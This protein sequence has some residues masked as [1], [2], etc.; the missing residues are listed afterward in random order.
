VTYRVRESLLA[1]RIEPD[2]PN[3]FFTI[4][5]GSL[6]T[7]KGEVQASGFV[8]VLYEGKIAKVFMRDITLRADR[9]KGQAAN[10]S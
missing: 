8:D 5:P 2:V 10:E 9:I 1:I 7:V 3:V 6:I 4:D